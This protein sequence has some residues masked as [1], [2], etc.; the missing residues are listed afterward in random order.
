MRCARRFGDAAFTGSSSVPSGVFEAGRG[1]TLLTTFA[2]GQRRIDYWDGRGREKR[3][4]YRSPAK[5][6]A[7]VIDPDRTILLDLKQTNNSYTLAP[8][9]HAAASFW[10][11]HYT[12]WLE[13]LLLTYASLG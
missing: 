6:I 2:D 5:P 3:F 9:A 11:A 8:R 13:H 10:A 12:S 4:Q 1:I 7:A